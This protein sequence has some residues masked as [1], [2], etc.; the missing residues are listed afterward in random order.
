MWVGVAALIRGISEIIFAFTLR[1]YE[2]SS[3]MAGLAA[4]GVLI[5][6]IVISGVLYQRRPLVPR[7][8]RPAG[9][10]PVAL[11]TWIMMKRPDADQTRST[12]SVRPLNLDDA[13]RVARYPHRPSQRACQISPP[14]RT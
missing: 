9:S 11:V 13:D 3:L 12:R 4:L 7:D 6:G 10:L 8:H 1:G 5:A 14:I 2:R